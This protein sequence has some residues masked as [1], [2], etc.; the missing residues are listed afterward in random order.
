[1]QGRDLNDAEDWIRRWTAQSSAAADAAQ[2]MSEQVAA[3]SS[4]ATSADGH[5]SVTVAG[6]GLLTE[7]R[8][9]DSLRLTGSQL[10]DK[11]MSTLRLAQAGLAAKVASVVEQTVGSDSATGMSVVHSFQHRFPA[12]PE[13]DEHEGRQQ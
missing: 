11:I 13:E 3:L 1:M 6:S 4:T 7:L 9:D 8:L 10:A 2:Q 12:P 5:I